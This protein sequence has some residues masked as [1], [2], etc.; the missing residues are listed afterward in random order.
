MRRSPDAYHW[1]F[2]EIGPGGGR[3]G[4]IRWSNSEPSPHPSPYSMRLVTYWGCLL[5][6]EPEPGL[7]YGREIP[8]DPQP[9]ERH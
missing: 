5:W 6:G 8:L 2:I 9:H 7:M 3:I 1:P 4:T